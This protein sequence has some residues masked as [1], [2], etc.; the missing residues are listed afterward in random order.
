MGRGQKALCRSLWLHRA[1]LVR[2]INAHNQWPNQE[3]ACRVAFTTWLKSK[4]PSA[5]SDSNGRALYIPK[6]SRMSLTWSH[7]TSL[8]AASIYLSL[9]DWPFLLLHGQMICLV[10]C[11]GST[12]EAFTFSLE[13]F[14]HP[15]TG[16]IMRDKKHANVCVPVTACACVFLR[17]LK[18]MNGFMNAQ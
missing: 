9:S 5:Q 7:W 13:R 8:C 2:P 11:S 17:V 12:R 18:N 15:C 6:S 16:R 1:S 4:V 10:F 14:K 3:G